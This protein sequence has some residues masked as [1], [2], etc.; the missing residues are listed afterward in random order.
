MTT[1]HTKNKA[2]M[3]RYGQVTIPSAD[4][5]PATTYRNLS[6]MVDAHRP[7]S[8][9]IRVDVEDMSLNGNPARGLSGTVI[10]PHDGQVLIEPAATE[11]PILDSRHPAEQARDALFGGARF[12]RRIEG[13]Q[14]PVLPRLTVTV[15]QQN[16][17]DGKTLTATSLGLALANLHGHNDVVVVD[18]NPSGN[19]HEHTINSGSRDI[20]MFAADAKAGG[21]KFGSSPDDLAPF[22]NWQPGGWATVTRSASIVTKDGGMLPML[23]ATDFEAIA[24]ALR[25]QF[26][27]I[28][29][30]TGNN[31]KDEAWQ[32]LARTSNRLVFVVSGKPDS[33]AHSQAMVQDMLALDHT[34]IQER[35]LYLFTRGPE[36]PRIMQRLFYRSD[37]VRPGEYRRA[38]TDAGW[39][40]ENVPPD[41]HAAFSDVLVWSRLAGRTR[42]AWERVVNLL[43]DQ[44]A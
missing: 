28:I 19:L 39:R 9:E 15:L 25:H 43:I 35:G 12:S 1:T 33:M 37:R 3:D 36:S 6:E 29:F 26:R 22:I 34:R 17:G 27:V 7:S 11:K 40:V 42:A 44:S 31:P 16:G 41:R 4:G 5:Y 13:A 38:L 18:A 20:T 32:H 2:V 10:I 23:D 8:G 24:G 14:R 21:A 30:D